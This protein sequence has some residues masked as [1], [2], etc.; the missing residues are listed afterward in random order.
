MMFCPRGSIHA[1]ES[2]LTSLACPT[3]TKPFQGTVMEHIMLDVE[4]KVEELE[5]M[6]RLDDAAWFSLDE[7]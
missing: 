7:K 4:N 1:S 6:L 2:F 3:R 5:Y